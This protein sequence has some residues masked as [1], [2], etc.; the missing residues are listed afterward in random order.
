MKG[1]I[2]FIVSICLIALVYP[3]GILYSVVLT[4][5]KNGYTALDSYLYRCALSNDQQGNTYLA[6]LFNDVL[7]KT[8]GHKFGDPDET[9]SSVLGKNQL[10]DKLSL[11][12][13][14]VNWVLNKIDA[15]HSIKSIEQ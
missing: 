15:N 9:I 1:L 6:K 8:G 3:I 12:G 14:L 2:L 10:A 4:F 7:I 5:F 11:A 13:K